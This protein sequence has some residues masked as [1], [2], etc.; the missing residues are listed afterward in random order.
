[1]KKSYK[2]GLACFKSTQNVPYH[3]P[4]RHLR[5]FELH[6]FPRI[7][8]SNPSITAER[9]SHLVGILLW[10]ADHSFFKGCVANTINAGASKHPFEIYLQ[11]FGNSWC[12]VLNVI[13][14][15]HA[16]ACDMSEPFPE[17]PLRFRILLS[18]V[19]FFFLN[20]NLYVKTL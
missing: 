11:I 8:T 3:W 2:L 7:T 20:M 4:L 17:S 10:W 6:F 18:S 14:V 19:F 15:V 12:E 9:A 16:C 13:C 1:M 5:I